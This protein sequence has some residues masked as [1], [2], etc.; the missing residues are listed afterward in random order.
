MSWL[1]SIVNSA[2]GWGGE[3][4]NAILQRQQAAAAA[5]AAAAAEQQRQ[6]AQAAALGQA[7]SGSSSVSGVPAAITPLASGF[8]M[9]LLPDTFDDPFIESSMTAGRAKADDYINNMLARGT[10]TATGADAARAA[11]AAQDPTVRSQISDIS[12]TLLNQEREK[13]RSFGPG[14]DINPAQAEA[15]AFQG[16]FGGALSGALPADLYSTSGLGGAAGAATNSRNITLDPYAS[17]GGLKTGLTDPEAKAPGAK[18]RT[19]AV[20]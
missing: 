18:K 7:G 17:E 3:D 2:A 1:S 10:T 12:N 19:T 20:F 6:Q 14:G 15:S 13:L 11:L 9:G 16:G 8:E 5:A 4:P